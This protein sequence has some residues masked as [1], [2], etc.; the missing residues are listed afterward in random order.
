MFRF[1]LCIL[2]ALLAFLALNARVSAQQKDLPGC[3]GCP[4]GCSE[5]YECTC[6]N[7]GQPVYVSPDG[8]SVLPIPARNGQVVRANWFGWPVT[9]GTVISHT[10][11]VNPLTASALWLVT[12]QHHAAELPQLRFSAPPAL[13]ESG[14]RA[15]AEK[16]W[17]AMGE[18]RELRHGPLTSRRRIGVRI[19]PYGTEPFHLA[20]YG[21]GET[22]EAAFQDAADRGYDVPGYRPTHAALSPLR[23][24]APPAL[25]FAAKGT[26]RKAA[27]NAPLRSGRTISPRVSYAPVFRPVPAFAF[28]G[29][30]SGCSGGV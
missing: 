3:P 22:W 21:M 19:T 24:S 16:A 29:G 27:R 28:Q 7:K 17:P 11:D 23:F 30:F 6:L 14:A 15:L 1:V 12:S 25:R 18:V 2:F 8:W 20:V 26:P 4:C 9:K 5:G 10:L 13:D